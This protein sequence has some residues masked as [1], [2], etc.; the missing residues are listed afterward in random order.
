MNQRADSG[1]SFSAQ[2]SDL[3]C[4]KQEDMDFTLEDLS[5]EHQ[6]ALTLYNTFEEVEEYEGS[7]TWLA[8]DASMAS[9]SFMSLSS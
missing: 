8:G 4:V 2:G 6:P 9:E 1:L 3:V 5:E 7:P